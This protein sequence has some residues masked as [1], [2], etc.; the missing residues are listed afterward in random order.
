MARFVLH[1][2]QLPQ[3]NQV[4]WDKVRYGDVTDKIHQYIKSHLGLHLVQDLCCKGKNFPQN[5]E[6]LGKEA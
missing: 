3:L 1:R 4:F 2:L 6:M 5:G